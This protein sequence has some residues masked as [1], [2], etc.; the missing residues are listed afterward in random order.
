MG[1]TGFEAAL[2]PFMSGCRVDAESRGV[3]YYKPF[4]EGGS[5][6]EVGTITVLERLYQMETA[7]GEGTLRYIGE[8]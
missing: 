1:L 3:V 5:L 8:W 2:N 7:E 4:A 6:Q